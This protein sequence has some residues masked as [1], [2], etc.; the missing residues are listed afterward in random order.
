MQDVLRPA[1]NH[2]MAGI[3]SAL[4]PNDDVRFGG[5][6]INDFAFALIAPLRTDQDCVSHGMG[7]TDNKSSRCI[8]LDT[9]GTSLTIEWRD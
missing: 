6:D 3:I 5:E 2:R 1:M 9:C 8:R 4:A 7:E